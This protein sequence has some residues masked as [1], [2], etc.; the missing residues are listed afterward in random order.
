MMIKLINNIEPIIDSWSGK[1]SELVGIFNKLKKY[2]INMGWLFAGKIFRMVLSMIAGIWVAR[3]LG[4]QMFGMLSFCMAVAL[5]FRPLAMFQLEG[6]CVRE[7]VSNPD[8]KDDILGS[9]FV[10]SLGSG[11]FSFLAA[12][13]VIQVL[14]PDDQ[15]FKVLVAIAGTGLVFFCFEVFDYRFQAQVKSKAVVISRTLV[16]TLCS[17][18]KIIGI[19]LGVSVT[20]FVWINVAEIILTGGALLLV[21]TRANNRI[22]SLRVRLKWLK[23]LFLDAWPLALS[24]LAATIYLRI[25]KIMIG[26]MTDAAQVGIYTAATRLAEA[27]Y[28]LPICIMATLY[29]AVVKSIKDPKINSDAYMQQIYKAMVLIGYLAAGLT[30]FAAKPVIL[31]LFGSEY[32]TSADVLMLYIWSG[33][34]VN[35]AMV[36]SAWL[37]AM[38]LTKIQFVST[39]AGAVLN[40]GLNL[41]FIRKFGV[42]GAAWATI[43]SYAVEGYLILF[44]FPKT[45]NQARMISSAIFKP[46]L[47]IKSIL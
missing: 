45:R 29:P 21:Y 27:W 41:V 17:L 4:V 20:F 33:M 36:K 35:I 7:L 12:M 11:V 37:K 23:K 30:F 34:F 39:L 6:I 15:L 16:I 46:V 31:L 3:Y 18:L 19:W 44:L 5:L 14:Q 28:F 8:K 10:L 38:N 26:Q 43:I 40:I 24:G 42:I 1:Y 9:A 32:E 25:D 47:K 13:I 22:T 2:L